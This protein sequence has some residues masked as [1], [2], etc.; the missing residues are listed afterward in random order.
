MNIHTFFRG[1]LIV[2]WG[3]TLAACSDNLSIEPESD[4]SL[5]DFYQTEE[6]VELAVAGVYDA[7]QDY[8]QYGG[9]YKFIM[10]ARS[11]NGYVEDLSRSSGQRGAFDI[12]TEDVNNSFLNDM[13]VSGY[14]GIQRANVLLD[15]ITEVPM[16]ADRKNARIGEVLF[17]RALTYFNFVRIW[18]D[19]PLVV[20]VV[21]DPFEAFEHERDDASLVY[22]QIETDLLQAI[23]LMPDANDAGRATRGAARTLL[24]KMY[25]TQQRYGDA[26]PV[27]RDV[28]NSGTYRLLDD[29]AS[30]FGVANENNEEVIFEVQFKAGGL[31]EGSAFANEYAPI[32]ANELVG[33]VGNTVGDNL[34]TP[35]LFDGYAPLDTRRELIGQLEDGRLY[36]RKY[37]DVPFADGDSDIDVIV[38][39]YADVLLMLAEVLNEQGYSPDGEAFGY[40]NQIRTRAGV[41]TY[42]SADLLS[43]EAFRLAIEEER[44]LELAFENHRWFDLVRTGRALEVMNTHEY[45]NPNITFVVQPHQLLMPVPQTQLDAS[46]GRLAQNPGY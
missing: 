24:A 11:D 29:Y 9:V 39:R 18:G 12:F 13:W 8:G 16:A 1:F 2:A 14:E 23:D 37:V 6:D 19:V 36:S 28:I 25:L 38:L 22:G 5:G 17:L 20:E 27:L 45:P 15:R 10:E 34:P 30:V 21:N 32:N 3:L 40:L 26:A 4:L 44:R 33:G 41:P 46:G 7:L 35:D 43:Q 42:T 31:G